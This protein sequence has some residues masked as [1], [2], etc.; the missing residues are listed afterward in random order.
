MALAHAHVPPP[1]KS[2]AQAFF[3][4]LPKGQTLTDE[5]WA[6]RHRVI[7]ALLFLHAAGLLAFGWIRGLNPLH[8]VAEISIL[9]VLG[10][11]ARLDGLHRTV[12]SVAA[13][14]GL[15][16]G[17]ALLVHFSGG[18]IEM[19]FHFFVMVAVVSLYQ[20]WTPFLFAIGF[21][22]LHH[23]TAGVLDPAGVYN[24]AAAQ[25]NPWMWAGLHGLFIT[26]ESIVLLVGW[27]FIEAA[28]HALLRTEDEKGALETQLRQSQKM[29]AVGHLAGGVAHDF[30]NILSVIGNYAAFL[31]E[32]L[33]K[34]TEDRHDAAAIREAA[35]RG[36]NLTRQLLT[37]SRKEIVN[38]Q[39][40]NL[41]HTISDFQKMF[42]K[43]LPESIDVR[44][45]LAGDLWSTKVDRGSFE[46][47]LM[48]LVVNARDA[49]GQEGS[50]Q[51]QTSNVTLDDHAANLHP[52]LKPGPFVVLSVSDTGCG[53]TEEVMA[54]IFEPFFTTKERGSGTG[55]GLA[56]A[57]GI[58]KQA[59]GYMTVYSEPEVGTTFR[60]YLPRTEEVAAPIEELIQPSS[61]TGTETILLAEDEP[62]LRNVAARILRKN[63]YRVLLAESGA[64]AVK[65][66]EKHGASI[67]LLLTD[68]VMPQMSGRELVEVTSLPA[69]YMSGYTNDIIARQG[70]LGDNE[71]FLQKPFGELELLVKIRSALARK[72]SAEP[73]SERQ[74]DSVLV[75]DDERDLLTIVRL[76][77][78]SHHF[79]VLPDALNGNEAIE[80]A[81]RYQPSFVILDFMM[82]G[83]DGAH[84]A[85]VIREVSPDSKIIA[86]SAALEEKP[87][88]ADDF[89]GKHQIP[90]LAGLLERMARGP[91]LS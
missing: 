64:D 80:L 18:L 32:A 12:R 55:L 85:P 16:V 49:M 59:G 48:N 39:V 9:V 7:V 78:D 24:H 37:F 8:V 21:V 62:D 81:Q 41:N 84:V 79:K 14:A 50:L 4:A 61:L 82:P 87:E 33:P 28:N 23:G 53:M 57:Y 45:A 77:L 38:P 43:V 73:I 72:G 75:V 56:T 83:Q 58:V 20:D 36:A 76:V 71:D 91:A 5:V 51:L 10:L 30:N 88:W 31:E 11:V 74:G 69:V 15:F 54:Q 22:V 65:Q 90:Q 89:L 46:Q 40:V 35:A 2:R 27:R 1:P 47:L 13:T 66:W 68:V 6:Q 34:G 19:H 44:M 70:V 52:G 26:G 86:F 25:R 29:E 60:I 63:G 42:K 17:S 67:D 3:A